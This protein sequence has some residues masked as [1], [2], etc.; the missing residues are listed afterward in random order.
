[1]GTCGVP[2]GRRSFSRKLRVDSEQL[3]SDSVQKTSKVVSP[4]SLVVL[5]EAPASTRAWEYTIKL[6]DAVSDSPLLSLT[7][8]SV[9]HSEVEYLHTHLLH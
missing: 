1:M 9:M 7:D 2:H 3:E 5:F 4:K 8:H 6:Y